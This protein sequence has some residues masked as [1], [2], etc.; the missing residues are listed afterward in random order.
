MKILVFSTK[1]NIK[2]ENVSA[3]LFEVQRWPRVWNKI[4]GI[5]NM[6]YYNS[7]EFSLCISRF[8]K[9]F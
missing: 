7:I 2:K 1:Q 5:C 6:M 8:H 3:P 4:L 9:Y